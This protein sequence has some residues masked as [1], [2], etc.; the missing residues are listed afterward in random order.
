MPSARSDGMIFA[1][2]EVP[3]ALDLA[4]RAT[5]L[6]AGVVAGVRPDPVAMRLALDRSF[7]QATDLAEHVMQTCRV[8]FRTSH[9]IVGAV[10]RDAARAGLAGSDITGEMLDAAAAGLGLGELGLTGT[11]LTGVLDPVAIVATRT[12]TGGAAPGVVRGMAARCSS[13]ARAIAATCA[14]RRDAFRTAEQDLI[15]IAEKHAAPLP[16]TDI[17][18]EKG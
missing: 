8:D 16:P 9:A 14:E 12:G 15:A 2:G 6:M 5:R 17:D 3:R 18:A 10:V 7:T 1:Y 4:T 11:D 13:A